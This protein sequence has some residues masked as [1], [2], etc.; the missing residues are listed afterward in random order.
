MQHKERSGKVLKKKDLGR[1]TTNK[2]LTRRVTRTWLQKEIYHTER[3][4]TRNCITKKKVKD[5]KGFIIKKDLTRY[6][7]SKDVAACT[8]LRSAYKMS[9]SQNVPSLN[10]LSL[11]VPHL[12]TSNS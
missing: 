3:R 11:N 4:N 10:F 1:Y 5:L 9:H 12:K 2:D 6:I 8:A 7:S